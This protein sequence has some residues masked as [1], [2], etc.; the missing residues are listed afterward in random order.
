VHLEAIARSVLSTTGLFF[1]GRA[2]PA[3][4]ATA[5]PINNDNRDYH[6]NKSIQSIVAALAES[7]PIAATSSA[8]V[9]LADDKHGGLRAPAAAPSS[10]PT[11]RY[12]NMFLCLYVCMRLGMYVC[13]CHLGCSTPVTYLALTPSLS[14]PLSLSVCL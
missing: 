14:F 11:D 4:A 8:S 6:T 3:H 10:S 9:P 12:L 7:A 5:T 2:P 13:V 1:S